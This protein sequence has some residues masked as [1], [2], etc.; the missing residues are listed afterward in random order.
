M[1]AHINRLKKKKIE[2]TH[3]PVQLKC[4]DTLVTETGLQ[5]PWQRIHLTLHYSTVQ[6]KHVHTCSSAVHK[7]LRWVHQVHQSA[8]AARVCQWGKNCLIETICKLSAENIVAAKADETTLLPWQQ[9]KYKLSFSLHQLLLFYAN[10]PVWN[11][12]L[13]SAFPTYQ[14]LPFTWQHP[15]FDKRNSTVV[16]FKG[17]VSWSQLIRPGRPSVCSL[18]FPAT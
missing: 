6:R 1:G 10:S 15:D 14:V 16:V 2:T 7:M 5:I 8:A 9:F 18:P 4:V 11:V 17:N 3:T 13:H 12:T